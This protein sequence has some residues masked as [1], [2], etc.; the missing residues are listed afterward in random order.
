MLNELKKK[1]NTFAQKVHDA[2]NHD[3]KKVIC[4]TTSL[5]ALLCKVSLQF[6]CEFIDNNRSNILLIREIAQWIKFPTFILLIAHSIFT[7][8]DLIQDYRNPNGKKELLKIVGKL[9]SLLSNAIEAL[10]MLQVFHFLTRS[11]TNAISRIHLISTA[12]FLFTS[13]PIGCYYICKKY[14]EVHRGYQDKKGVNE[15]VECKKKLAECK[16]DLIISTLTLSLGLLNF[17]FKRVDVATTP[18]NLGNGIVY[19]FNLSVTI[20]IICSTVLLLVWFDKLL[21]QPI[22]DS[23]STELDK[24]C[25]VRPSSNL[26]N[27]HAI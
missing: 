4:I 8:R 26:P 14:Q 1:P 11:N 5:T 6:C 25:Y 7:L 2:Y 19:S 3:I 20:G 23:L 27:G 12:L 17:I 24:A 15:S 18:I 13:E 10:L 22:S 21:N 16:K 9:A